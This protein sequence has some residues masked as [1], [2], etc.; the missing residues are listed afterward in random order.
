MEFTNKI[1]EKLQSHPDFV[2]KLVDDCC[3]SRPR[4]IYKSVVQ[5]RIFA[6]GSDKPNSK[7][8]RYFNSY[9]LAPYQVYIIK[10]IFPDNLIKDKKSIGE[11]IM[12]LFPNATNLK[13]RIYYPYGKD[14][15]SIKFT[16]LP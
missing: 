15:I 5:Y 11:F 6:N 16:L 13:I 3:V 2:G 14:A 1:I 9:K 4:E 10:N 12:A 8:M 7:I